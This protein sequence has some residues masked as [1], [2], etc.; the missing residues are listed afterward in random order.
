[1]QVATIIHCRLLDSWEGGRG[2]GG[3]GGGRRGVGKS[4]SFFFLDLICCWFLFPMY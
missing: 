2:G 3:G 4:D 1:M